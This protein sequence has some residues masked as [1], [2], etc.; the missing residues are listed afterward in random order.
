MA[1]S[2]FGKGFLK[3]FEIYF[4]LCLFSLVLAIFKPFLLARPLIFYLF[5]SFSPFIPRLHT[6]SAKLAPLFSSGISL[7]FAGRSF[8]TFSSFL[9]AKFFSSI[10][11]FHF[12]FFTFFTN[13][14]LFIV[15]YWV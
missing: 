13:H 11:R 10:R 14:L 2:D 15:K 4:Q 3:L 7:P 8:L 9:F 12:R 6:F 1:H 5:S